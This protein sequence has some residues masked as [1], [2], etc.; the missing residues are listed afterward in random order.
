MKK[1]PYFSVIIP[2]YNAADQIGI[3][4]EAI[5]NSSYPY[6]EILVV[7]DASTDNTPRIISGQEG[8]KSLQMQSQSGPAA[9]RNAAAEKASGDV[10]L[11]VDSD[12]LIRRDTLARLA[13]WFHEN[14]DIA[15]IFGSYDTKP[16]APNF[17]SQYKNLLHHY[18]HQ[19]S[20]NEAVTFWAGCGAIR[21]DIFIRVGGFDQDSYARPCIEDIELGLRLNNLGEK[22]LLDKNLQVKH[23]KEWKLGSLLKAD[24]FQRAVPW[25]RLILKRKQ[26]IND[27]NLHISQKISAFLTAIVFALL[28]G[29]VWFPWLIAY[30]SIPIVAIA[31][32][33]RRL[34]KFYIREK[35]P[36]FT[37]GAFF[38]QLIYY[39]YSGLTFVVLYLAH[40]ISNSLVRPQLFLQR[41]LIKLIGT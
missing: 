10:L 3:C 23:L 1:S 31:W 28:L 38:M 11:F 37:V 36:L 24:I 25:T 34:M 32:I 15:A 35:G 21:K 26:M 17:L 29:S 39:L 4:L 7:D 9:A 20:K 12:V 22:I 41:L 40:T 27:L 5:K 6:Y 33:N 8:I 2:A 18:V 14:P 30:C 19:Q 13:T 16:A